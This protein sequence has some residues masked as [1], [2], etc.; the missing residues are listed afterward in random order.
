M[1]HP[2]WTLAD[3]LLRDIT[4]G[5]HIGFQ[6]QQRKQIFDN[7]LSAISNPE[8]VTHKLE[9]EIALKQKIRPFLICLLSKTLSDHWWA[10]IPQKHS[11]P[12]GA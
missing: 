7:D 11:M 8:A 5:V 1:D 4:H 12:N 6:G 10:L 3:E 2:D 9:R